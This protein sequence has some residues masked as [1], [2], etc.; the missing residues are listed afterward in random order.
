MEMSD[1]KTF[2]LLVA[3]CRINASNVFFLFR[4]YQVTDSKSSSKVDIVTCLSQYIYGLV[5]TNLYGLN[6]FDI[7]SC[8]SHENGRI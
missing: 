2:A 1:L 3:E 5:V 4:S 8:F 7:W 6:Q